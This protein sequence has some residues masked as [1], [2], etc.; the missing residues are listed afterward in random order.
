M[1][2]RRNS[3]FFRFSFFI[4]V[5]PAL[6]LFFSLIDPPSGLFLGVVLVSFFFLC[7]GRLSLL[8]LSLKVQILYSLASSLVVSFY[9]LP[10]PL[11][12]STV[13]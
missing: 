5:L 1:S 6:T 11:P 2:V 7:A 9:I 4:V 10:I 8:Q 12:Y 13:P 3:R